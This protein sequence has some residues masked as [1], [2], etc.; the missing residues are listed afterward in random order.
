M[1]S[2]SRQK[3]K[4]RCIKERTLLTHLQCAL[5]AFISTKADIKLSPPKRVSRLSQ[6]FLNIS[7]ITFLTENPLFTLNFKDFIKR[8]KKE[9][10]AEMLKNGIDYRIMER[11]IQNEKKRE[12]LHLL[13][14]ILFEDGFIVYYENENREGIRGNVFIQMP[15][16]QIVNKEMII[17]LGE[18]IEKYCSDRFIE[19]RKQNISIEMI[20]LTKEKVLNI[21]NETDVDRV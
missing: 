6:D 13:E 12:I 5:I 9:K 15:D 10:N 8:R 17:K 3:E 18:S 4:L 21:I 19:K 2:E 7:S 1:T 16:K 14:D 20:I 11:K